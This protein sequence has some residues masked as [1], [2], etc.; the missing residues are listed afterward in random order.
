MKPTETSSHLSLSLSKRFNSDQTIHHYRIEQSGTGCR[1]VA[2]RKSLRSR[3]AACLGII[4]AVVI[5]GLIM[6]IG[7]FPDEDPWSPY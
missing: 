1:P 3:F 5:G 7:G 2:P 4:C 6:L